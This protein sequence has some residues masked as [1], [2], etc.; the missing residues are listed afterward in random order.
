VHSALEIG[1]RSIDTAQL[2]QNE[3][4][5]GAAVK[6]SGIPRDQIFVTTKMS[7][8][9]LGLPTNYSMTLATLQQSLSL[10]QMDYVDLYLIHSPRDTEENVKEQWAAL[11]YAKQKGW[12]K[13]IGV[14]DF[15]APQLE[16]LAGEKPSVLQIELSPFLFN[17]R[18]D[19]IAYCRQNVIAVEPWGALVTDKFLNDTT[20][21]NIG[22]SVGMPVTDVLLKWSLQKG[23]LPLVTS[24]NTTHQ[25]EDLADATSGWKLSP[26]DIAKLDALGNNSYV[27]EAPVDLA[28]RAGFKP[29]VA[30]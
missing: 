21:V 4:S 28:G 14:S 7:R 9:F 13:S 5:V 18:K 17:Y 15:L 26:Q 10:L 19:V 8:A 24:M 20:L 27:G 25:A 3:A 12:A 22:K 23:F 2:Y 30:P 16:W 11:Q 29:G 1:Y 6:S